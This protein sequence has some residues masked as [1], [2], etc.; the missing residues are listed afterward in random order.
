MTPQ[1][2]DDYKLPSKYSSVG[3]GGLG[4]THHQGSARAELQSARPR[5]DL[6][7]WKDI[8][9]IATWE[10]TCWYFC[11]LEAPLTTIQER[12]QS[13]VPKRLALDLF[14]YLGHHPST[15]GTYSPTQVH[16][17]CSA[18]YLIRGR[19]EALAPMDVSGLHITYRP[20]YVPLSKR[21]KQCSQQWEPGG[22]FRARPLTATYG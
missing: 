12:T 22:L 13:K 10:G 3:P 21:A 7:G 9:H 1:T 16:L 5:A 14:S 17:G 20:Q 19:L 2:S 18:R 11:D 15:S 8:S 4:S 6:A